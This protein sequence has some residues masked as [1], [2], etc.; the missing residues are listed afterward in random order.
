MTIVKKNRNL[1]GPRIMEERQRQGLTRTAL[2]AKLNDIGITMSPRT[3]ALVEKQQ[4]PVYDKEIFA[5]SCVL[6][7]SLNWLLGIDKRLPL[8]G[9]LSSVSETDEVSK[10]NNTVR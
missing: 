1:S 5:L 6:N 3:L 2:S 8:E 10:S 9:K 7:A 4:R